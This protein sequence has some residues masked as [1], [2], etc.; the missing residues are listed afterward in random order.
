[1]ASVNSLISDIQKLSVSQQE[2]LLSYLE[3]LLVLGTQ[4]GQVTQEVKEFR[5]AKGKTCPHCSA[6]TVSRNGKYKG[7]QRYIC[8]SCNKTFTDFTNSATYKSKKTLDKWLKYAKC[9]IAG[10]SIRKSAKIVEINIATSFF[11]RHKILDCIRSFFG[12]GSVEG[13]IEADEVFFAESFKGTKPSKMPRKSR[14]RGKQIKKRGI[15]NEQVCIATA[16]DRQGNL[17][18]ELLCRGRMTHQELERLYDGRVGDNPIFC[19]DSHKSYV[20]IARDFSLEHKRIQ[21]G[22]HKEGIYHIQHINAVHSK[23]KKWMN[24]FNG[25]ATKYISNYLYWFKWLQLFETDKEVVKIKNFMVQCNVAHA[26]TRITDFK[27][28]EPIFI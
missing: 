23:L 6:E 11:W 10:Y 18:M 3:D 21:R 1:M 5:F 20:Q 15:S 26:Y 7:K 19:T 27:E 28:R 9:M 14:K 17:I 16:I 25:V 13:V 12:V 8:K 24:K 4:V 22:K 2:Q